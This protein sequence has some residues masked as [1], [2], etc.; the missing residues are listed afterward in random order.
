MSVVYS[1]ED[2]I[3][4]DDALRTEVKEMAR[5]FERDFRFHLCDPASPH[6]EMRFYRGS[7]RNFGSGMITIIPT[8]AFPALTTISVTTHSIILLLLL[9][10]LL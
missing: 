7:N 1:K 8:T 10:L 9:V 4:L 5:F 3:P 2:S 6:S